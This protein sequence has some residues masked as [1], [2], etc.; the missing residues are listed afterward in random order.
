LPPTGQQRPT[1]QLPGT[2]TRVTQP[3][4]RPQEDNADRVYRDFETKQQQANEENQKRLEELRRGYGDIE[5]GYEDRT[6]MVGELLENYGQAQKERLSMAHTKQAAGLTQDFISRGMFATSA[7][8]AGRRSMQR[9]QRYQERQLEDQLA[10]EKVGILSQVSQEELE[11]KKGKLEMEERVEETGPNM[12]DLTILAQK[13]GEGQAPVPD[14]TGP[15]G[16]THV[17]T[18]PEPPPPPP[19][20]PEPPQPPPKPEPPGPEP[21]LPPLPPPK[22]PR[23]GGP[24]SRPR[25][26]GGDD[27]WPDDNGGDDGGDTGDPG[28]EN[29]PEKEPTPDDE[30]GEPQ[31]PDG[32]PD[33]GDPPGGGTDPPAPWT[34]I[35]EDIKSTLKTG[36]T[37][38]GVYQPGTPYPVQISSIAMY[39]GIEALKKTSPWPG[40]RNSEIK[41]RNYLRTYSRTAEDKKMYDFKAGDPTVY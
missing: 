12:G 40:S 11:A 9:D 34:P 33:G 17:P 15:L 32:P 3:F 13:S 27:P 38:S 1:P 24:T 36:Y 26:G 22:T 19:K 14:Y 35:P 7:L 41:W 5:Q 37:G 6:Q 29:E 4:K 21:P 28:P 20:P 31:P 30:P 16:N 8:D 25:P 18:Q 39:G 2:S 23:P 10:R